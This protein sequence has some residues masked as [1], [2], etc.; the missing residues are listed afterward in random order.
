MRRAAVALAAALT[1]GVL[2]TLTAAGRFADGDTG[3]LLA[4]ELRIAQLIRGLELGRAL[5][6]WW[7][8]VA[9]Q[10]P[11][12]YLPGIAAALVG[13]G[14]P[15]VPYLGMG[16]A[17]VWVWR[18]LFRLWGAAG[19][20][21]GVVLLASPLVWMNLEQHGRDFLAGAALLQ[22]VSWL[23]TAD[24]FRDRRASVW[25]GAWLGFG[26]LTKYTFPAF[27]LGPCLVAGVALAVARSR[28]RWVNFAAAVGGFA[29]VAGAWLAVYG[30]GVVRYIGFSS[31]DELRDQTANFRDPTSFES[32]M[33]YPLALRDALSAPGVAVVLVAILVGLARR[34][35][36][37]PVG[38]L[39]A[40]ITGVLAISRAPAAIDRYAI[41]FLLA[42]AAG[43]PALPARWG[44]PLVVLVFGPQLFASWSSF[45]PGAA[46][47]PAA[48]DHPLSTA[49]DLAWPRARTYLPS[50]LDVSAWHLA[51]AARSIV[52][53]QGSTSGTIGFLSPG[54]GVYPSFAPVLLATAAAGAGY[55]SA[56]VNLHARGNAPK[57]FVGPLF[58]GAWPDGSFHTAYVV[59][60]PGQE[61]PIVSWLQAHRGVERARFPGPNGA[62]T[63][64]YSVASP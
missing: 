41:P 42:V 44:A 38:L 26:F 18:A 45:R 15:W 9:P 7:S 58:D 14:A 50:D 62:V 53:V 34:D 57:V 63:A 37:R 13:G 4:V 61:G 20:S 52:E 35:T 11:G 17:L 49:R 12:G 54:Q 43:V 27:A 29:L 64:V 2:G 59:L 19:L 28:E 30:A 47:Q 5:S 16:V 56:V 36:R 1:V 32:R 48:Y 3:H 46:A 55:D 10:P 40:T 23:A 21:G 6:T 39:L 31:S 51:D 22:A 8:L 33:Y 60:A 25:F 24:G